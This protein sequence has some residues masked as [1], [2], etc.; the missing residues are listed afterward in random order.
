MSSEAAIADPHA[1]FEDLVVPL[2]FPDV[3]GAD[4]SA[5]LIL[6]AG[7]S[8]AGVGRA[9]G[10][11]RAEHG[12]GLAVLSAPDLRV[13]ADTI[14]P[15]RDSA[16]VDGTVAGWLRDCLAYARTNQRSLLLEGNFA[17]PDAALAVVRRFARDGF[18]TRV[19][20]IS[21][22]RAES[23]L[24]LASD[25]LSQRRDGQRARLVDTA[26]HDATFEGLRGL[27]EKAGGEGVDRVTVIDR[28]GAV[29]F[30][31]AASGSGWAPGEV[32]RALSDAQREPLTSLEATQWLSE[33]RRVTDY[34]LSLREPSRPVVEM[35]VELH[36]LALADVVP[37]LP[38]PKG[39]TMVSRQ[40]NRHATQLVALKRLVEPPVRVVAPAPDLTPAGPSRG[41]PSR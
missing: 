26:A 13:I 12:A 4:Q 33:L 17:A 40:E 3:A 11:L 38:V 5:T 14:T 10:R 30:D 20:M 39:S 35:L 31:T 23:L 27:A 22:S 21:V 6:L 18:A 37:R 8:G 24:A 41:G 32:G 34:A 25:H 19:V 29:R 7:Q 2:V 9:T 28:R 36:A 16:V 1:G 15:G